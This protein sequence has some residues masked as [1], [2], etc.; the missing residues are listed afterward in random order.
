MTN[1]YAFVVGGM[2]NP[3][4]HP[5][6][7]KQAEKYLKSEIEGLVGVHMYDKHHTFLVFGSLN[8]AKRARNRI[9]ATGNAAGRSIMEAELSDDGA[10]LVVGKEAD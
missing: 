4:L 9:I 1:C 5:R 8:D 3:L 2:P 10:L 7:A 6:R